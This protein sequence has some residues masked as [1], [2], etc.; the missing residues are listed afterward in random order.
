MEKEEEGRNFKEELALI[1]S[2][3]TWM[4]TPAGG[5][6]RASTP[7]SR[8]FTPTM[9]STQRTWLPAIPCGVCVHMYVASRPGNMFF[10][11]CP[12]CRFVDLVLLFL[13]GEMSPVA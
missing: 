3:R 8:A 10:S 4:E 2:E 13:K 12:Q 7:G 5:D 1:R 6:T 11:S 9:T